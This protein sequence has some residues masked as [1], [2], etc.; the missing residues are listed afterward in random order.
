M[1]EV[2]V[3]QLAK[4]DR[5]SDTAAYAY[6]RESVPVMIETIKRF[7]TLGC[8]P[9]SATAQIMSHEQE[10]QTPESA[11]T[12]TRIVLGAA[13][14]M[15]AQAELVSARGRGAGPVATG[16]EVAKTGA[17]EKEPWPKDDGTRSSGGGNNKFCY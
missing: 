13:R 1:K 17:E 14:H 5:L 12:M 2:Q 11:V 16:G 4:D 15:E 6:L 7:L 9:Q 8:T 10:R 3:F